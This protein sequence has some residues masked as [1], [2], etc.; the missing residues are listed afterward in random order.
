MS[1]Q[2]ATTIA[3]P[4]LISV[5]AGSLLLLVSPHAAV[6]DPWVKPGTP[7]DAPAIGAAP[8]SPPVPF[9]HNPK[10]LPPQAD[11][12][13]AIEQP[14][15]Y[16]P[17]L[18][19]AAG[20]LRGTKMLRDLLLRTYARG[21]NGGS[22][23]SCAVGSQSEH[24][25]G[26]AF[27]WMLDVGNRADRRTAGNFLGWLLEKRGGTPA[28]MARRLG[29]MYVIYN[30]KIWASYSPGWRSYSGGDPH[31]SHIHISLSFNGG[32]GNTSFWKGRVAPV[33][34]GPCVFFAGSPAVVAGADPRI[35]RCPAPAASPRGSSRPFAWLGTS[36]DQVRRAQQLLGGQ[37]TGSFNKATRKR[38]IAFQKSH[39]LPRTGTLDKPTWASL[40]PRTRIQHAP[41]WTQHEAAA[42]G[43]DHGS[44]A[45]HRSSAGTAP[46]AL[47]VA[48]R[49]PERLR[50]G[51]V[52]S[53]TSA[54]VSRFR[55]DH[56]MSHTSEVTP[57]VWDLLAS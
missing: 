13:S 39:D 9:P 43:I 8:A 41:R 46:Y 17:Q 53:R 18:S 49:M 22:I 50:T 27:D 30:R 1:A 23:R 29:I 44:P 21:S 6:A 4:L 33:D 55:V 54:A 32:R 11:W 38:L 28:A 37:V 48:L 12:G 5:V 45:L 25:D 36:G 40:D 7:A 47:Q 2:R 31:T 52:G 34:N 24:K 26:R 3:R 20:P 10:G 14:A 51:F 16:T 15:S 35:T 42:W 56:G 19:C 57:K